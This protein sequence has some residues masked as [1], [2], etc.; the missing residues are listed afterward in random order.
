MPTDL[1]AITEVADLAQPRLL[2]VSAVRLLRDALARALT[3]LGYARVHCVSPQL[4]SLDWSDGTSDVV[5]ADV[6]SPHMHELMQSLARRYPG[7]HIIAFGVD[8]NE[9]EVLACAAV[10]AAGYLLRESGPAELHAIIESVRRNELICSPRVAAAL[11]RRAALV[12]ERERPATTGSGHTNGSASTRLTP[13]EREVL[14]LLDRGMS[15]KEIG[16][17][18]HISLATV[19]HHVHSILEKLQVR[20]RWAAA[21]QLHTPDASNGVTPPEF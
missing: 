4:L 11:F 12:P 5:I 3:E 18:L 10:G 2:V 13:R 7:L 21:A 19:K 17:A 14:A 20:R 9:S 15:N 6:A 1:A 8:D 16:G